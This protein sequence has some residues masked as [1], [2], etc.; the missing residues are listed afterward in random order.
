MKIFDIVRD[1]GSLSLSRTTRSL[2]IVIM[3][4]PVF[5]LMP[6]PSYYIDCPRIGDLIVYKVPIIM[7][8]WGV[9]FILVKLEFYDC[10]FKNF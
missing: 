1:F 3:Q 10:K 5:N 9:D 4:R 2:H 8:P 6:L 7:H